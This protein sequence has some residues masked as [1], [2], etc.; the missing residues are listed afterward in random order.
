MTKK[1][2]WLKWTSCASRDQVYSTAALDVATEEKE[3]DEV[4]CEIF[5]DLM[6]T[7]PY[8]NNLLPS[9]M[10]W[11]G[12]ESGAKGAARAAAI[13]I[14]FFFWK[15]RPTTPIKDFEYICEVFF[16]HDF[17]VMVC[18]H[19]NHLITIYLSTEKCYTVK[20]CYIVN[21]LKE[22]DKFER[23][24]FEIKWAYVKQL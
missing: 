18:S 4:F 22:W 12:F 23:H 2:T 8:R 17:D 7:L 13:D 3:D 1:S 24:W 11:E 16:H 5:V 21:Y 14:L 20:C 15:K 6:A 19:D 10:Y 9:K